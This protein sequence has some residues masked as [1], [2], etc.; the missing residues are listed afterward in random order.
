MASGNATAIDICHGCRKGALGPDAMPCTVCERLFHPK[1][2]GMTAASVRIFKA[3]QYC[4]WFCNT[5]G[6]K[7]AGSAV[8]AAA[9][10]ENESLHDDQFDDLKK[11]VMKCSTKIDS[12][13][14]GNYASARAKKC[15]PWKPNTLPNSSPNSFKRHNN[16]IMA[17]VRLQNVHCI[18]ME[19][20]D[21]DHEVFE[22]ICISLNVQ[23]DPNV[24]LTRLKKTNPDAPHVPLIRA[25]FSSPEARYALLSS[26]K[27]L[28][29]DDDFSDVYIRPDLTPM[30]MA[31][32]RVLVAELKER[33]KTGEDAIIRAGKVIT[34]P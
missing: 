1:C 32:N 8:K 15:K 2:A 23:L 14:K 30:Q 25:E 5:C 6:E 10:A 4:N 29:H 16:L 20:E 24:K 19:P 28:C 18:P 33:R 27:N 21:H 26:A 13:S 22:E 12:L 17:G 34:R 9:A 31:A 11:L 7:Y 3:L